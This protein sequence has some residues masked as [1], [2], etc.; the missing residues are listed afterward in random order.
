MSTGQ[1]VV[2]QRYRWSLIEKLGEGDA[3]EVFRVES[4]LEGRS[5]ILKRP[6]KSAFSSDILR[7]AAQIKIEGSLLKALGSLAIPG[8]G[9]NLSTPAWLDQ[10]RPEDGLGERFFIVVERAAG[11]DLKTMRQIVHF[12]LTDELQVAI[13]AENRFFFEQLAECPELPQPLLTRILSGLITFLEAAH[14]GE[15]WDERTKQS[16][17]IWNDVKPEHLYWDPLQAGLTIIDWGNGQ[18]LE[19]DGT[20]KDRQHSRRD[21]DEQFVLALGQFLSEASPALYARLEWPQVVTPGEADPAGLQPLKARLAAL[22]AEID[23]QLQTLRQAETDLYEV[24]RPGIEHLAQ[25][26]E[27]YRQIVSFGEMPDFSRAV[28]LHAR[29]ALQMISDER[30]DDFQQVCGRAVR[31]AGASASKWEQLAAIARLAQQQPFGGE[32][33]SPSFVAALAAGVADDWPTL[34]WELL[35]LLNGAPLPEWWGLLSSDARRIHLKLDADSLTPYV[36]VTRLFYTFQANVLQG[37]R[38]PHSGPRSDPFR[39]PQN[40]ESAPALQMQEDLLKFFSEEVVQKWKEPEPAPPNAGIDY[41][42][43]ASLAEKL[44]AAL[45]GSREKLEKALAQPKAQ[46]DIVLDAWD[47]RDFELARR[48]LRLV[49]LWDPDR[50]RVLAADRAIGA[51]TAWLSRL[52]KG[53]GPNEPFYD[54][55]TSVEL[56][57]RRLRSQVGPAR[58]LDGILEALKR[59]RK[60]TRSAD[61]IMEFPDALTEIPWLNEFRSRE[62]LSLPR[63]RPLALERDQTAPRL[64]KTVSGVVEG[65]IGPERDFAL[66]EPLDTWTPEAR[67]SSARVFSGRLRDRT[68]QP[69]PYAIKIMR[70]DQVEYALPLFREEIQILTLLRDAPGITPMVECGF[71]RLAA[72]QTFPSDESHASAA[73][74][75][76]QVVRYG[77]EEAQNFLAAIDRYLAGGWLPYLALVRR[78]YEHNLMRYCDAGYT[79][80]AFLPLRDSL[81]L[82]V[83][84]GDILQ[85]AHDRNIVYRDH[86]ILHYYWDAEAHSVVMIDWN[87]ARRLPQ[88]MSDAERQFDL[89]QFGARALHHILTGRPAMGALPLGPNRPEDIERAALSYPVNW[90]YDDERLPKQ[91]KEI[92]EQA[93]NQGYTHIRD[94]RQDLAALFQQIPDSGQG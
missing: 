15:V 24:S 91:A 8:Q 90:T 67:G 1:T 2:G 17:V 48:G 14:I 44:E 57:G 85:V 80:G 81:A 34:L 13:N 59:L 60:G 94:L 66:A 5:A 43:V 39:E 11:V 77:V 72:D 63:A 69:A 6:R 35:T 12:G 29:V 54:Y 38:S 51:A 47:R 56:D 16:G 25:C 27:L 52:R 93:L 92:L 50:R 42:D 65:Q 45:P 46:A 30:L 4:L 20:T 74:L 84:I 64:P 76:G 88:G 58:W 23:R 73:D 19:P 53:A 32:Q 89:A 10:S 55:L 49:L 62:I 68:G 41:R 28:N 87:I 31:L 79:H 7:Q 36:A 40:G 26:D 70:P 18:F 82:A 83:Q 86:K 22:K 21:D 71:L 37:D 33:L 61:L 75:R 3:G 78:S 9:M